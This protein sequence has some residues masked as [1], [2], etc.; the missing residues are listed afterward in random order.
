MTIKPGSYI[1][2]IQ[3]IP[4]TFIA[5]S[6]FVPGIPWPA[7]ED[8]LS[9]TLQ[10][11]RQLLVI[12]SD[13]NLLHEH[14]WRMQHIFQQSIFWVEWLKNCAHLICISCKFVYVGNHHRCT[15][16]SLEQITKHFEL[17]LMTTS[18]AGQWDNIEPETLPP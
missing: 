15:R 8:E 1:P 3:C 2:L 12:V 7:C 10:V 9:S 6:Y 18:Q 16:D 13:E 14:H 11:S 5:E 4:G 17:Q